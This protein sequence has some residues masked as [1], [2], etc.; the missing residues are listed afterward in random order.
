MVVAT[1]HLGECDGIRDPSGSKAD[2][3]L[4]IGQQG[5]GV[6]FRE[7]STAADDTPAVTADE[8]V[9]IRARI[10]ELTERLE[11]VESQLSQQQP[12]TPRRS[13]RS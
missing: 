2:E 13:P 7:I 1:P 12:G 10:K 5:K 11:H 4:V 8:L 3:G 9:E 6:Y